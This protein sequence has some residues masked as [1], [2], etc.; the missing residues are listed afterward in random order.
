MACEAVREQLFERVRRGIGP[1]LEHARFTL[2]DG[3]VLADG[4]PVGP[5]ETHL[6][7]SIHASRVHHHRRTE[8]LD[9]KGQGD[10][11]V[12]FGFGAHRAIVDVDEELGLVRVVRV[13][14]VHDV[15]RVMNPRMLEGQV[16]G[17]VAQGLGLAL[18]EEVLL[19]GGRIL[20]PSFTDYL[21][22]TILDMPPVTSRFVEEPEPGMPYGAKG[23]AEHPTIVSV[24][25]IAAALRDAT[26]RDL[27]RIPVRVDELAGLVPPV[28]TRPVP[29]SPSVPGPLPIPEYA[30]LTSQRA[31]PLDDK[32]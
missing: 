8:P 7:T 9:P 10:V 13:D 22:P 14:A 19:E 31:V 4:V 26:G 11:H 12:A 3:G 23:A 15:G 25:A 5:I 29:P 30:G 16:E 2:E 21:L 18:L 17:G 27:N 6:A 20:N 24:A 28:S 1:A 32:G